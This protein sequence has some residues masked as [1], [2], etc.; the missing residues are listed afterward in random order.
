MFVARMRAW[1]GGRARKKSAGGGRFEGTASF[2]LFEV[3]KGEE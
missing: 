1:G 3:E 2:F